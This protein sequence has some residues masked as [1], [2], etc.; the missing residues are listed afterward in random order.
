MA[1][2]SVMNIPLI[3]GSDYIDPEVINNAISTLDGLGLDY[4]T[5][6]GTSGEW[7]YRK[8]KSGRCECGI[9]SK[10]FGNFNTVKW[11][12]IYMSSAELQF[13]AY[14][15]SFSK[16]PFVNIMYR[17]DD[18]K[19]GGIIHIHPTTN[20]NTLLTKPPTFDV[21]DA[22]GPHTYT[23]SKYGIFA[24]GVYK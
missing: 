1:N 4:V 15:F 21:V 10:N 5:E 12:A 9:D 8:W 16:P 22:N 18:N 13:P 17:N 6:M 23:N 3:N 19:Y 20:E 11:G 14:P 2:T 24:T 7:W